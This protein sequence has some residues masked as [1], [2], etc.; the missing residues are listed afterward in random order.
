MLN[1]H[2]TVTPSPVSGFDR[3]L[4]WLPAAAILLTAT[5]LLIYANTFTAPFVFD[6]L[7]H[8]TENPGIRMSEITPEALTRILKSRLITR[9]LANF[10]LAVNFF[11]DQYD[12]RGHHAVNLVIHI[13][14]ALLVMLVA[15][16]TLR[17]CGSD[18]KICVHMC[19]G[20][21]RREERHG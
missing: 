4:R 18:G 8:I 1:H 16:E 19:Q 12:V 20:T 17:L 21:R 2:L 14:T 15:R 3:V 9:P 7:P 6:D 5:A 11:F 10:S 13:I